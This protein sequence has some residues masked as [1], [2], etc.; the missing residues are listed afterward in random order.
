MY[1]LMHFAGFSIVCLGLVGCEN[2]GSQPESGRAT[3]QL[4]IASPLTVRTE[5]NRE[6]LD[7]ES[8]A[9]ISLPSEPGNN[10]IEYIVKEARAFFDDLVL[11]FSSDHDALDVRARFFYLIGDHEIARTCWEEAIKLNARDPYSHNGLGL[12]HQANNDFQSALESFLRASQ[13]KPNDPTL[14]VHI[15]RSLLKLGKIEEA[16]EVIRAC[17]VVHPDLVEAWELLGQT[18]QA[19]Q[20]YEQ[21]NQAFAQAVRRAPQNFIAQ[22]GMLATLV[23]MNQHAEAQKWLE[24]QKSSRSHLKH[25]QSPDQHHKTEVHKLTQHLA[26]AANVYLKHSKNDL[27]IIT[28]RYADAIS[29]NEESP[30]QSLVELFLRLGRIDDA[31]A[32]TN[33]LVKIAPQRVDYRLGLVDLHLRKNNW[34]L[35]ETNIDEAV[36]LEPKNPQVHV[37]LCKLLLASRMNDKRLLEASKS[38]VKLRGNASDFALMAKAQHINGSTSNAIDALKTA[39]EMEPNNSSYKSILSQLE[40]RKSLP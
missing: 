35:A 20:Q 13:Y 4:S 17:T 11:R 8:R 7:L 24:L 2:R 5:L 31:I 34:T 3:S 1:R 15:S 16:I 10:G 14:K 28:L 22:Q 36:A 37:A 38:L 18:C 29:A 21:A 26:L 39:I 27:A 6:K 23:R 40:A 25:E 33:E 19:D 32:T 9:T 12:I 30:K